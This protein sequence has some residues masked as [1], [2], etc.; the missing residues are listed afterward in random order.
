MSVHNTPIDPVIDSVVAL[1]G[2]HGLA[3]TLSALRLI[4][5]GIT[6]VVTV[7]DDGGS[8]GRIRRELPSMLPPGD[9]R[10]AIAALSGA[11]DG[12]RVFA[13]LLQHRFGG[14]GALAG[15]NVGNLLITGLSEVLGNDPVAALAMV[16]RVAGSVGTV[17]PM[18]TQPLEIVAN[19][20]GLDGADPRAIRKIRGQ[21]AVA[22]TPGRVESV[23]LVPAD[24]PACD[25]ACRAV[26][27][28]NL[29][30]LGPGSWFTS[31]IPH[32][33]VPQLRVAIE[34]S[35]ALRVIALNLAAQPGETDNFSPAELLQALCD[36]APDLRIDAV[37]AD[38]DAL[39]DVAT[40][41]NACRRIGATLFVGSIERDDQPGVHD[42]AKYAALLTETYLAL[43]R[44]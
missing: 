36:H 42:Q 14:Q 35:S 31:V 21:V 17:L 5:T 29:I 37:I 15:H 8:S 19:V 6:A 1:G 7:A 23:T 33:M 24:P 16:G 26:A 12:Q 32:L 20:S 18:S 30:V 11:D 2:G 43:A 44:R 28:A 10:M 39:S 38:E 34:Q 3:A 9:L 22:T 40:L 25:D 27:E 4:A 13:E 41:R